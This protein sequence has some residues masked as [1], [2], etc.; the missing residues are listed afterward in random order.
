MDTPINLDHPNA[1]KWKRY[2]RHEADVSKR[3][4]N[5]YQVTV[6]DVLRK[7]RIAPLSKEMVLAV[8]LPSYLTL[9]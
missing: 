7:G 1:A 5:T 8:C 9:S 4:F 3:E 2:A 6:R